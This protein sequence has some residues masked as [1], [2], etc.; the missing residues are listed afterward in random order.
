ML[1]VLLVMVL[2]SLVVVLAMVRVLV[3]C[4]GT[5]GDNASAV[6]ISGGG[7]AAV[8]VVF[9][10]VA[11]LFDVLLFIFSLPRDTHWVVSP[12]VYNPR[13]VPDD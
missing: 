3:V 8:A 10:F 6:A 4:G 12:G 5:R 7:A 11:I 9:V 1:I 2:F 13:A